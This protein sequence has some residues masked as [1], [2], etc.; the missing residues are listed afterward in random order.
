MNTAKTWRTNSASSASTE[1]L[2]AQLALNLRGGEVVELFSDLGGGKTTFVRGLARG[3]NSTDVV[4]SPTFKIS[5][6]YHS[7]R[8]LINHFDFY[9]LPE[10][11]LIAHELAEVL[12]DPQAV[13]IIEWGTVVQDVLPADRLTVE[14]KN[15]GENE[16]QLS[17][18]YPEGLS[19]LLEGLPT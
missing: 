8:F 3:L 14:I 12:G 1:A 16:R 17:F 15:H 6:V 13:N 11:G 5:N 4:S 19:Y 9:R 7:P 2:A 10:A 18:H